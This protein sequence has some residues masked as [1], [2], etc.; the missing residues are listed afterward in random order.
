M[1]V[2]ESSRKRRDPCPSPTAWRRRSIPRRHAE[3]FGSP[4]PPAACTSIVCYTP[5]LHLFSSRGIRSLPPSSPPHGLFFRYLVG[6]SLP[7]LRG[8]TTPS[9]SPHAFPRKTMLM[10]TLVLVS[11]ASPTVST[12]LV[13]PSS[14]IP[15]S[16]SRTQNKS[17]PSMKVLPLRLSLH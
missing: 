13:E 12:S 9:P 15:N 5:R 17:L 2:R 4:F 6:V 8:R 16:F 1:S 10:S 11:V 14:P 3:V 7:S